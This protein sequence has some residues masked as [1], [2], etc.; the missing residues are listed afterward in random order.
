M[1]SM[2]FWYDILFSLGKKSIS[3]GMKSY[4]LLVRNL[5]EQ[6]PT[7]LYLWLPALLLCQPPLFVSMIFF[8]FNSFCSRFNFAKHI[9]F[10]IIWHI[11]QLPNSFF[12]AFSFSFYICK[13]NQLIVIIVL[14]IL[15]RTLNFFDTYIL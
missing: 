12:N 9:L 13:K 6:K 15:I 10:I 7:H 3:F 4:L 11:C 8:F 2:F 1:K 5:C 14:Q